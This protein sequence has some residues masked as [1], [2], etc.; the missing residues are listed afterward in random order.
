ML[1][2]KFTVAQKPRKAENE[3]QPLAIIYWSRV[4]C[5]IVAALI[6]ILIGSLILDFNLLNSLS[7]ALG[8]YIVTYYVYKRYFLEKIEKPS[9]IFTTGVGAYFL[10]WLVMW[11]LIYTL[12]FKQP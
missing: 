5:G 4:L 9:T 10:S 12:L 8:V 3:M 1:K 7:I 11:V 2:L 6:S